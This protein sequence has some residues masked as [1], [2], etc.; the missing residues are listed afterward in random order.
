MRIAH[1]FR[2]AP[3]AALTSALLQVHANPKYLF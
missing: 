3:G 2:V 1:H